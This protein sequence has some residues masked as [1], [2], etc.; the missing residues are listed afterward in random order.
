MLL[1]IPSLDIGTHHGR[2]RLIG[3]DAMPLDDVRYFSVQVL[4]PSQVL[5][6]GDDAAEAQVIRDAI[7]ISSGAVDETESSFVVERIGYEDLSVVRLDDFDALI[8]LDPEREAITDPAVLAYATAGGGV[9]VS[10]GPAVGDQPLESALLPTLVRRWRSPE[11]GTFLQILNSSHRV[12]QPLS[13]NTPW[14]DF[15]VHQYWQVEPREDDRLLAQYAG[16]THPAVLERVFAASQDRP[17]GRMLL[18]TTPIP[19]LAKSTRR[20]NELYSIDAWPAWLLTRKIADYLTG[21]GAS[22]RMAPV[23]QPQLV[24]LATDEQTSAESPDRVQ[25]FRP[26][27]A[28]AI[29]VIVPPDAA[30]IAINDVSRAGTYWIRG[31][32]VGDGFSANLSA[33][34][35][36]FDRIS[37]ADLD[38]T[39]GPG[40]YGLATSREEIEFS[41]SKAAQRV[42]LHSPAMLLAL[43][44][45]L[46]EQILSNRFYRK[47]A[48]TL[49]V[50]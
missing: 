34:A 33:D 37:V 44:I 13:V 21:R 45:F 47:P 2:I 46:M 41:D 12:T 4:P 8:L 49:A 43:A 36:N 5:L 16:T 29:P 31:L 18:L 35:L 3:D 7:S 11:P 20:W 28:T 14:S 40:Q 24:Q 26:G 25:L 27:A 19:A 1:T 23:G 10:L 22:E 6:V 48:K 15:R 30:Q 9:F 42:S 38:T 32:D 39:F 50:A 17:S